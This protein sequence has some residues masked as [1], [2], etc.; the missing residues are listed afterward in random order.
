MPRRSKAAELTLI[1]PGGIETLR[2]PE[3]PSNLTAKEAAEWRAIVN[4][5]PPDWFPRETHAILAQYC[6]M[7]G[8][9]EQYAKIL[10]KGKL[11]PEETC[12]I[13]RLEISTAEAVQRMA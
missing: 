2:R 4:R 6:R 7:V 13:G 8:R 11:T 3:P 1:G 5:L 12:R 9:G 10:A